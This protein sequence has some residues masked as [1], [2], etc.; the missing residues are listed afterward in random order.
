MQSHDTNGVL[1]NLRKRRR[2][3]DQHTSEH[4]PKATRRSPESTVAALQSSGPVQN[5]RL[6]VMKTISKIPVISLR[7]ERVRPRNGAS[8][9]SDAS[10]GRTRQR[11]TRQLPE[12]CNSDWPPS[13]SNFVEVSQTA[14]VRRNSMSANFCCTVI[15]FFVEQIFALKIFAAK[16]CAEKFSDQKFFG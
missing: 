3:S 9:N 7:R 2:H 16:F 15:R 4:M 11:R 5:L 1:L 12:L 8:D 13:H 10:V 14:L 6:P